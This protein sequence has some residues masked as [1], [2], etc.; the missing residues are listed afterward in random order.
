[1]IWSRAKAQSMS[2]LQHRH[3][4]SL[5]LFFLSANGNSASTSEEK[6]R[7]GRIR[8]QSPNRKLGILEFWN[9]KR[10]QKIETFETV[11]KSKKFDN[12]VHFY[13]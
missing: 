9:R 2:S 8:N 10:F 13:R 7:K 5:K 4:T 3:E 11:P 1:V 12:K 6:N